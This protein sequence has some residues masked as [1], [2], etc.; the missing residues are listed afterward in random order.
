MGA[1]FN[2]LMEEETKESLAEMCCK[3]MD[4]IAALKRDRTVIVTRPFEFLHSDFLT[5]MNDIGRLGH[6]K[7]GADA[8]E[9]A[10]NVRKIKR[11]RKDEIILHAHR[12][13]WNYEDSF[14][15]DKLNTVQA[16]LAAAAFN[17]MLEYIFSQGE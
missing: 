13:L 17:C 4:E 7:F 16:H 12:H 15:H 2:N 8:F 9:V 1:A 14:P 3:L 10:G 5:L 11:H 6:E